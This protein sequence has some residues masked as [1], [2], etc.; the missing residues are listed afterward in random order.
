MFINPNAPVRSFLTG[1]LFL[2]AAVTIALMVWTLKQESGQQYCLPEG[3][4]I[5]GICQPSG[6][7]LINGLI[8]YGLIY[9][10]LAMP[11]VSILV[12]KW[13]RGRGG[14]QNPQ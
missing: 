1:C 3:G 2:A 7:F 6:E 9:G 10:A 5:Y 11:I 12:L 4:M 14:P 13:M 8:W